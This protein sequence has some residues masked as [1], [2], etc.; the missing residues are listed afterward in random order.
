MR[1]VSWGLQSRSQ[2]LNAEVRLEDWA[3]NNPDDAALDPAPWDEAGSGGSPGGDGG[4]PGLAKGPSARK[5]MNRSATSL[6][7][8]GAPTSQ[9][10]FKNQKVQMDIER[11]RT[12]HQRR[13]QAR[14]DEEQARARSAEHRQ[15]LRDKFAK[16][17]QRKML[18]Q[19]RV[20]HTHTFNPTKK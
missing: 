11:A 2:V 1:C 5:P 17:M 6:Y 7:G 13:L 3:K 9:R 16:R 20:C 12:R 19:A 4:D 18:A 10:N 15:R 14:M 8:M